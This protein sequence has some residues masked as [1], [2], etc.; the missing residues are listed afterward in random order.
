LRLL[1]Q[2]LRGA[3]WLCMFIALMMITGAPFELLNAIPFVGMVSS[4]FF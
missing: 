4:F 3:G 2:F 1:W